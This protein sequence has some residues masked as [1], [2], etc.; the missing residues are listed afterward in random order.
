[1]ALD[2]NNPNP[3]PNPAAGDPANPNPAAG[4]PA[5]PNPADGGDS[6][7]PSTID[8]QPTLNFEIT[9]DVRSKFI[10]SD[11]KL[12][13]KYETLEQLAEG[14]KNL[15]DK[16]AQYVEDVKNNDKNLNVNIEAQ[17]IEAKKTEVVTSVLPEFLANGMELTPE[18]EA[19]LVEADIDIRDVKLGAIDLRDKINAAHESVG[20]KESY[21]AMMSWATEKL[22]DADK[23]A[24]DKDI[25][26]SNSR[27]AIK[28]LYSEYEAAQAD[29]SYVAPAR[30][31]GDNTVKTVQPYTDRQSLLKDKK[32]V[33]SPAGKR[34]IGAQ[35]AYRARLAIT[36][37]EVWRGY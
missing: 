22:N 11:G 14:H 27:F 9:D 6:N 16:H 1:M 19:K 35:K 30:L 18:I 10:T 20:G 34:D 13:G 8:N 23:A 26:G 21:D 7:L 33:D 36:E 31:N 3:N 24:F 12:L 15:Q 25:M 28:G 37:T 4:D 32:Y 29:G 2:P 5:N 17:Q